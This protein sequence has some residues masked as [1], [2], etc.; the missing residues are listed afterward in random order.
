M[1]EKASKPTA[2]YRE[3]PSGLRRCMFCS[4]FRFG[5]CTAVEGQISPVAVCDYWDNF[6]TGKDAPNEG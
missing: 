2:N 1:A 3:H 6:I 5:S 4:M